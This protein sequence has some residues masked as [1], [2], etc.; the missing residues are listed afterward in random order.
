MGMKFPIGIQNFEKLR[1][2]GYQYVDK[3]AFVY[4]LVNEGTYYF[5]SRPRRFGKSLLISTL[6]AYMQG[7]KELF[8][9]LALEQLEKDWIAYPILHL[10]LNT[11]KYD[12]AEA[13]NS[14]LN[15]NLVLWEEQYGSRPEEDTL[16]GRFCG[17][18]RR[19]CEQTGKPVVVLVDEYDKPL[20]NAIG[21]ED[22]QNEYRKTLK[23]VYSVLKS[24]DKYIKFGFLTGVTK[25][26][27]V[28]V[29]SDLNNLTDISMLPEYVEICGITEKELHSNFDAQVELVAQANKLTKEECYEELKRCYDG[30]HFCPDSVGIYNP[31]SL[32]NT[33]AHYVFRDYWFETGTPTFL[34][35]LL[36]QTDFDLNKLTEE[37]VSDDVINSKESMRVNPV[38]VIYQSGY[39]TISSYDRR[40]NTYKLRFPNQ[41]VE[42]GFIRYLLPMYAAVKPSSGSSYLAQLV[43][44]IEKGE[45]EEFMDLLQEFFS[46]NDYRVAGKKELYFQNVLYVVFKMIGFYVQVER[47]IS[48]SR[49]DMIL[50]T[51]DY[52][53]I[54]EFK[55]D[56]SA[57][58]ALQ[59]IDDK[60]YAGPFASDPRR[61]IK[62][63][64]N[65]SSTTRDI[66]E[67]KI[68]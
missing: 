30:Y 34:V 7:K 25:F 9:G 55:I 46:D 61:L 10:D 64:V 1:K 6:E 63:G 43:R 45:P 16:A 50:Q 19:A 33:L 18:I 11:E 31:F 48:R 68:V 5:L 22:L 17:I 59:Q 36:K 14:I 47:C 37:E 66:Q 56:K 40:F 67:W 8:K 41:E 62:I 49:M 20:L 26:E 15:R 23:A 24:Q 60:G 54:I 52:I 57:D 2:E 44:L 39:L 42:R 29:F 38:P 13:L 12:S 21:N 28:S 4:K 35:E 27:K 32:L 51:S 53:Y 65:F 58:E 3:T